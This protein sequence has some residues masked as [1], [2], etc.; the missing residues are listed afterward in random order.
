MYKS[1]IIGTGPAGLTAAIYLARAN[2]NPLVIEG[3][4]RVGSLPLQ[5]K[6]RISLAFPKVLW[7]LT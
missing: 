3:H 7:V 6:S 1:I 2:L 4:S 5:R